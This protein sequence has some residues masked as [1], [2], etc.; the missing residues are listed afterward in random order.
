[1]HSSPAPTHRVMPPAAQVGRIRHGAAT[2]RRRYGA[3]NNVR[4][5]RAMQGILPDILS[6]GFT[7]GAQVG[8]VT[9]APLSSVI[10]A[11]GVATSAMTRPDRSDMTGVRMPKYTAAAPPSVIRATSAILSQL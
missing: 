3:R 5:S 8:C 7:L 6:D 10:G 11:T 2:E 1:M 4:R 9:I